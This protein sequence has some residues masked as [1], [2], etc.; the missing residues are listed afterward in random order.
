MHLRRKILFAS[1]L[2]LIVLPVR[3]AFAADDL[4]SVLHK[5]DDAA[6]NFRSTSADFEFD[7]VTTDPIFDKVVQTGTVYY[8]HKD[9]NFDMGVH[10]D[11]VSGKP[12]PKIYTVTG[13]VFKMYEPL[14]DQLTIS[15]KVSKYQSY[16]ALG[17]GASG[18]DLSSKWEI[19]YLGPET[20]DNVKTEKLEMV[21]NDP[22]VRAKLPKVT[23]WID[24][25]RGV[26]LKQILNFSPTEYK[27]CVY[28]NFKVNQKLP[29]DAFTF[30][31]D[32]KTKVINQ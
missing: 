16:L 13:G 22:E 5:L 30:K 17:F 19:K 31:T 28:F 3:S 25:A 2:A 20:L 9:T 23:I 1:A 29:G 24:P 8:Q 11:K 21:P 26:S 7:E 15:N 6:K 4:T 18:K 27:V 12:V 32:G 14:I 10:I